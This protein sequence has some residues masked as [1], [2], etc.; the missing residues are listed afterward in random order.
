VKKLGLF[1]ISLITLLAL[2]ASAQT[3]LT[4]K[5]Q[6]LVDY[7]QSAFDG[8]LTLDSFTSSGTSKINRHIEIIA[9]EVETSVDQIIQETVSGQAQRDINGDLSI[10]AQIDSTTDLEGGGLDDPEFTRTVEVIVMDGDFFIRYSNFSPTSME[11]MFP[12][13]WVNLSQNPHAFS[14]AEYLKADQYAGIFSSQ[15]Q[16]PLNEN[17]V[18]RIK[19]LPSETLNNVPTRVVRIVFDVPALFN[20]GEVDQYL[21]AFSL[22]DLT[23]DT[24]QLQ[25]SMGEN[26]GLELTVWIGAEDNFVYRI[27]SVMALTVELTDMVSGIDKMYLEQQATVSV[28]YANFNQPLQ[29]D[30]PQVE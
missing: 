22:D 29:I 16:Y 19:E 26:A 3:G 18:F 25:T 6:S 11:V 30:T 14:G 20:N 2:P 4:D 10:S 8:F 13:N 7:V 21:S 15:I 9:L 24:N 23:L 27:E 1:I 28:T 5:D 12:D 17:T